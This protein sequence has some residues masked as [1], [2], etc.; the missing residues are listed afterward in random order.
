MGESNW[1]ENLFQNVKG[2]E[3]VMSLLKLYSKK[4]TFRL[5]SC[6]SCIKVV[7]KGFWE[8]AEVLMNMKILNTE[9]SLEL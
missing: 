2:V 4:K 6:V 7:F 9:T 5:V 3:I 8:S 1:S